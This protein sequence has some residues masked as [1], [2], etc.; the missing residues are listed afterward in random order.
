MQLRFYVNQATTATA[1]ESLGIASATL[2]LLSLAADQLRLSTTRSLGQA[3]LDYGDTV[4][5]TRLSGTSETTLF[6]GRVV[7]V[8]AAAD[9]T[10]HAHD[11]LLLGPWN[12]LEQIVYKQPATLY[13][14][15]SG[16]KISDYAS[17]VILS[18]GGASV[19]Q[20]IADVIA[21]AVTKGGASMAFTP[22]IEGIAMALPRDEQEGLTCAGAIQ[23]L[24][25]FMPDA[26][27]AFDYA[28]TPPVL[29]VR[30]TSETLS[31]AGRKTASLDLAAL[32]DRAIDRVEIEVYKTHDIDGKPRIT[33]E[34]LRHPTDPAAWATAVAAKNT[35]SVPMEMDGRSVAYE[36]ARIETEKLPDGLLGSPMT[37]AKLWLQNRIED[38]S[39]NIFDW[40][41]DVSVEYETRRFM[42]R[43]DAGEPVYETKTGAQALAQFPRVALS[44][45]P[46]WVDT[47]A[48]AILT[49]H[50]PRKVEA[51]EIGGTGYDVGATEDE[52]YTLRFTACSKESGNYR[53]IAESQ[54]SEVCPASLPKALWDSWSRVFVE[55]TLTLWLE[56]GETLPA[57]GDLVTGYP[58]EPEGAISLVQGLTLGDT[59]E[60]T[61]TLGPPEHL[62][63]HDLVELLRGFRSRRPA[64]HASQQ[65][66]G[67]DDSG[68]DT[69]AAS[70]KMSSGHSAALQTKTIV[71]GSDDKTKTATIDPS[72][73]Q[74]DK[75]EAKL[76]QVT[77]LAYNASS[78]KL[79]PTKAYVLATEPVNDGA[80]VDVGG[81]GTLPGKE[82][83]IK[84][85]AAKLQITAGSGSGSSATPP[86]LK[87][88]LPIYNPATPERTD[89]LTLEADASALK[90]KDG[91]P[92]EPGKDGTFD[93]GTALSLEVVTGV[94][95]D[96][97]THK[98]QMTK[99]TIQFYGVSA[100][101]QKT[102]DITTATAHSAEHEG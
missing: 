35:L 91:D 1:A 74:G 93:P 72:L 67:E 36:R 37:A 4:R 11:I 15:A 71:Y 47:T 80:E 31:L 23:R 50:F 7:S 88:I 38:L 75:T 77:L 87:L 100:G 39:E 97:S 59:G 13:D 33:L 8:R 52:V 56:D 25:R 27:T 32:R 82:F 10:R 64:W 41:A 95:Y 16:G 34:R 14:A 29:T 94:T 101:T 2:S 57:I 43:N 21:Y 6:V 49:V 54:A 92:G 5:L 53:R 30:R 62:S 63:P 19:A 65:E 58:G 46:H 70:A 40:P 102:V 28:Q 96:T 73:L 90:G 69:G 79:Q 12:D 26:A 18:G 44:A 81:G 76:R 24:L 48:E 68:L 98:L 17:R 3:P 84:T 61:L 99:R 9:A 42:Y 20:T 85:E 22:E 60:A 66:T 45:I 55:G 86:K 89:T 78:Q 51:R 83:L